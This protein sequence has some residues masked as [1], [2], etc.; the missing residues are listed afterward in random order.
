MPFRTEQ[1]PTSVS[2]LNNNGQVNGN[3][4]NNNSQGTTG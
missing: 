4:N 1:V 2:Q 3:S